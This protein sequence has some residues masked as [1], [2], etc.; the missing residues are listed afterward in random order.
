[1][2]N[3]RSKAQS[4]RVSWLLRHGAASAGVAIDEAGWVA[5]EDVLRTLHL[6]HANLL[7]IVAD[8]NK[9]RF[10]LAGSR[11]RACQGHS[12][13]LV[14]AD[15]LEASWTEYTSDAPI[16]HGTRIDVLAAVAREGLRPQRRTHVHLAPT[17]TSVVGKRAQVDVMLEVDTPRLRRAGQTIYAAPNGVILVRY[18]PAHALV[19]IHPMT[20][21]A[22]ANAHIYAGL[23]QVHGDQPSD[24]TTSA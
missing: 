24:P 12:G 11:I 22:R 14:A 4:K 10:E 21:R 7:A 19:A 13:G 1:M 2:T 23:L 6:T 15:T 17:L 16:W 3:E 8:D 18:V 9:Q 20:A 5:V